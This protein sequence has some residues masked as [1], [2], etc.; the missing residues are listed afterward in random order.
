MAVFGLSSSFLRVIFI[1]DDSL[2]RSSSGPD[3]V[4]KKSGMMAQGRVS[5]CARAG[6][7]E[8]SLDRVNLVVAFGPRSGFREN[9]RRFHSKPIIDI[10]STFRPVPDRCHYFTGWMCPMRS[11]ALLSSFCLANKVQSHRYLSL[12]SSSSS[13]SIEPC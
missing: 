4:R 6:G 7:A 2:P 11:T 5:S 10:D 3:Q 13:S 12:H 8:C 9:E 1:D